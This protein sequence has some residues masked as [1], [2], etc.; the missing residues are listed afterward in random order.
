LKAGSEAAIALAGPGGYYE[1]P[2]VGAE[3]DFVTSP[4]VPSDLVRISTKESEAGALTTLTH[5]NDDVLGHRTEQQFSDKSVASCP[6]DNVLALEPC[7]ERQDG[8]TGIAD[9][10][11]HVRLES[12]RFELA[13]RFA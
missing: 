6:H 1:R 13:N 9:A 5:V 12:R 10:D 2:P 7:R 11:M 3:G 8:L 4:H